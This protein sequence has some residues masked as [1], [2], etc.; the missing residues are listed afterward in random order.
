[1][2]MMRMSCPYVGTLDLKILQFNSPAQSS[3]AS[4]QT[5]T[6]RHHW[7]VKASQ[8]SL[9]LQVQFNGWAEYNAMQE[10]VRT[11][12]VRSL[13]T[14]QYPEVTVYWPARNIDNWTGLITKMEA[15]DERFNIAPRT[16]LS[17]LLIDSM[18]SEKTFGSSWTMNDTFTKWW[19]LD[20]GNPDPNN[21]LKPPLMPNDSQIIGP[22]P[23][24]A[25]VPGG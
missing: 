25:P 24:P 6:M 16:N 4:N 21:P 9:S 10:F 18:L 5:K 1:M 19:D 3:F 15:G 2:S 12:H 13:Q 22:G 11:H 8:Q 14:V 23:A 7:P 20:I 17:I